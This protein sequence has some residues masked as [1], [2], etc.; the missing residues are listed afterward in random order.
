M[1]THAPSAA[2]SG[3]SGRQRWRTSQRPRSRS[4]S[5]PRATATPAAP[6]AGPLPPHHTCH[7]ALPHAQWG[8]VAVAHCARPAAALRCAGCGGGRRRKE[9]GTVHMRRGLAPHCIDLPLHSVAQE[10]CPHDTRGGG[11]MVRSPA[12]PSPQAPNALSI[13]GHAQPPFAGGSPAARPRQDRQDLHLRHATQESSARQGRHRPGQ[14]QHGGASTS[15]QQACT[16]V[17]AV[18]VDEELERHAVHAPVPPGIRGVEPAAHH[19]Q[20]E[21]ARLRGIM[22]APSGQQASSRGPHGLMWRHRRHHQHASASCV[23]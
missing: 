4:C 1:H 9:G 18:A 10:R 5:C 11:A 16:H 8:S 15:M 14:T 21:V 6:G 17:V 23:A 19:L 12:R 20:S 3:Q 22:T 2:P 13:H 7:Q